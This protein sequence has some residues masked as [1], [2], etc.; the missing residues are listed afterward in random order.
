L[1]EPKKEL[2]EARFRLAISSCEFNNLDLATLIEKL[3]LIKKLN[4]QK[5]YTIQDA[6]DGKPLNI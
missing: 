6:R 2:G 1:S 5:Y 3:T 4:L